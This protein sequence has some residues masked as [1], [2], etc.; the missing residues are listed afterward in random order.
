MV[1]IFFTKMYLLRKKKKTVSFIKKYNKRK[2]MTVKT[3]GEAGLLRGLKVVKQTKT[4]KPKREMSRGRVTIK[5]TARR[6][7]SR[8]EDLSQV[9][10]SGLD[11]EF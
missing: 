5:M 8:Y 3:N 4:V 7:K 9:S 2:E 1:I 10:A 6:A 11:S